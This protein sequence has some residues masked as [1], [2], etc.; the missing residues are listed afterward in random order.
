MNKSERERYSKNDLIEKLKESLDLKSGETR[1]LRSDEINDMIHYLETGK[2]LENYND[3]NELIKA[4][5][6]IDI[7][8]ISDGYHSFEELYFHRMILFS[9]ICKMFKKEAWRSKKHYD[10]TMFEDY[11]IIGI[12]TPNG[13][14]SYHYHKNFWNYFDEI[15]ELEK[16]PEWDGHTS[17]SIERLLS[18][19]GD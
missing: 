2:E 18:L 5:N 16:A 19:L 14:Y 17:D 11:F 3:V 1:S 7:D 4:E 6:R 13:Q 9:I 15:K 8:K 10:N 12:N